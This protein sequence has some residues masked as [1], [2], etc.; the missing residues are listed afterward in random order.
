MLTYQT[1]NFLYNKTLCYVVV[2]STVHVHVRQQLALSV[3]Q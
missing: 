3:P 2:N 1:E